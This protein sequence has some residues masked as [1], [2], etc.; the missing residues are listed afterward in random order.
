MEYLMNR[1]FKLAVVDHVCARVPHVLRLKAGQTLM[2]DYRRVV[3]YTAASP[4]VPTLVEVSAAYHKQVCGRRL[5]VW[6]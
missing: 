5:T 2:I 6:R 4:H 1:A 3:E